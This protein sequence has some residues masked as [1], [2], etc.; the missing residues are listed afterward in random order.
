MSVWLFQEKG[1][2]RSGQ[3]I[4]FLPSENLEGTYLSLSFMCHKMVTVCL[5][6]SFKV[7]ISQ[8]ATERRSK[9]FLPKFVSSSD[10]PVWKQGISRDENIQEDYPT[11]EWWQRRKTKRPWVRSQIRQFHSLRIVYTTSVAYK[12]SKC[13]IVF[14][15]VSSLF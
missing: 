6:F 10:K 7:L 11:I 14:L 13:Q 15:D 8:K 12:W 3:R 4:I 9:F 5:L 2:S 1:V